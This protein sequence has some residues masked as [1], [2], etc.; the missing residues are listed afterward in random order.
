VIFFHKGTGA[1]FITGSFKYNALCG[2]SYIGECEKF[3]EF[4]FIDT[5]SF[6][7]EYWN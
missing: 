5:T 7:D 2:P 4:F 1:G 3:V 6:V